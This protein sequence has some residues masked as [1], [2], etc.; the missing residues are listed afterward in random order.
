MACCDD[1]SEAFSVR[2]EED[3]VDG[4]GIEQ[5]AQDS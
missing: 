5:G 3:D 4:D 1:A 2:A